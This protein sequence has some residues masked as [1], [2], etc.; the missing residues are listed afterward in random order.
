MATGIYPFDKHA[1]PK[2]AFAPSDIMFQE[3][4]STEEDEAFVCPYCIVANNILEQPVLMTT[5]SHH[6]SFILDN[7]N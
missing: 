4:Q 5:H 3:H 2:T 1:I 6:L 7:Y